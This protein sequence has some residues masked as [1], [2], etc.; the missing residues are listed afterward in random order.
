MK[1]YILE[2]DVEFESSTVVEVFDWIPTFDVMT[3]RFKQLFPEQRFV[4][5]KERFGWTEEM[6]NRLIAAD[7]VEFYPE[8]WLRLTP[9]EVKSSRFI[10]E[11]RLK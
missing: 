11:F 3:A 9:W 4:R 5:M 7:A 1:V 6:Y 8:R 2:I 10:S